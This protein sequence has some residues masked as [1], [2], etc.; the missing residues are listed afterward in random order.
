MKILI[1]G[2]GKVGAALTRQ[3]S[4]EGYDLTLIDNNPEVLANTVNQYDVM[5]VEGNCA[6]MDVLEEAGVKEADLLIAATSSDE[7]NMICCLTAHAMN[8]KL[9]TIARIRTPEYANQ[10]YLM[11]GIFALSMS[12][13][14]EKQAA[15]EML[16][17]LQ[18][19]GFLHRETFAKGRVEIVELRIDEDSPLK[20]H[21]LSQLPE[22]VGCRVLVCTVVRAG[23]A[24]A[25]SGDFVLKAGDRIYVTAPTHN[26]A[27][28]LKNLKIIA[29]PVKR[30][31]LC[32]AGRISYYLADLLLRA[33][34][35]V[36]IVEKEYA[37][38]RQISELLPRAE[39]IQG[40]ASRQATL[41]NEGLQDYDALVSLTGLD[42][43]NMVIS[44]IGSSLKVPHIITKLGHMESTPI[45]NELPIGSIVY[46]K[47][48]CSNTIVRYVRALKN[49]TGAAV[50]VHSIADGQAEAVE[51]LVD[52][53]TPCCGVPLKD[54]KLKNNVLI[55]CISHGENIEIPHGDSSYQEG[56]T[57]ILVTS[58]DHI[59]YSLNDIF[60]S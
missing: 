3:L 46:P 11:R 23:V 10:L 8:K 31:M 41:E 56:D 16:R 5:A 27:T 35:Q 13:N 28:L 54:L 14:P 24:S 53:D 1:A 50:A 34:M 44:M 4:S 20:N 37:A 17:L 12:V 57:L 36:K 43:L 52:K 42:E 2:D 60:Q 29:R 55:V 47:E 51:F 22:I 26:L 48:L 25:P 18:Y 49:Q 39:V 33:G 58:G 6:A 19:P 7:V 30:V 38:C 21:P 40:D 32:G 9:H 59:I 45:L 15:R